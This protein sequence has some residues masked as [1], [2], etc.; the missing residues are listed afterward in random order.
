MSRSVRRA[1]PAPALAKFSRP[2][3]YNVQKRDRLFRLL[4]AHRAH[5][6]IWIAGPP[7]AGKST[8]VASYVEARELP[9]IRRARMTRRARKAAP[10]APAALSVSLAPR[11][12]KVGSGECLTPVLA[13]ALA[14]GIETDYVRTLIRRRR[15]PPPGPDAAG[16]PWPLA[17]RTFGDFEIA[18]EG[19]PLVSKGKAQK[20]PLELAEGTDRVR[21]AR[22]RRGDADGA[23]VAG[24]R[25]R[26]REDVVRQQ[27]V[28]AA[29]ARRH[30]R[31]LATR[32]G[33][34]VAQPG[35][36]LGGHMDVRG[37]RWRPATSARRSRSTAGISSRSTRR[38]RGR[39]RSAT[40]CR[41]S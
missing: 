23:P 22:R 12:G 24:R 32:G 34:A 30:R 25:G 26:R 31:R 39:W 35:A 17:L 6:I 33:Q 2:R 11:P 4:D 20:K 3:L 27:P 21:R 9:G 1:S 18:R 13:L 15:L 28:P 40:G 37:T 16:W 7:G 5:P 41:R 14:H 10:P 38:S 19:V 36:G 29:Q 8:L